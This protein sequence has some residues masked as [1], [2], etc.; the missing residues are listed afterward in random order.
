MASLAGW[1]WVWVAE[2]SSVVPRLDP[3]WTMGPEGTV[4]PEWTVGLLFPRL[5][6]CNLSVVELLRQNS[7]WVFENPCKEDAPA[8]LSRAGWGL[9]PFPGALSP[10][11]HPQA[12]CR[13]GQCGGEGSD[14]TLRL[15]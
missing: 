5:E 4:D 7:A 14:S 3:E 1:Q 11:Q 9:A 13:Q 12:P 2:L 8:V 15:Q 6:R 10:L